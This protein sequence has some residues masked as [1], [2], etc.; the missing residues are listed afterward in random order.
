MTLLKDKSPA[1]VHLMADRSREALR[2][3]LR[4]IARDHSDRIRQLTDLMK[5]ISASDYHEGATLSGVDGISVSPDL[6]KLILNPTEG[7]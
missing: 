5:Q 7:L 2:A 1:D 3:R 6:E 4:N